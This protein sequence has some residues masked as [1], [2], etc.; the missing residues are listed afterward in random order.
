MS[1]ITLI[2]SLKGNNG[3]I[4]SVSWSLSGDFLI[5]IGT[6]SSLIIWGP[7][8][9]F[10]NRKFYTKKFSE[11]IYFKSWDK[12]HQLKFNKNLRTFRCLNKKINSN[13]F[14]ISDFLGQTYLWEIIFLKSSNICLVEIKH[15]LK[16]HLSE[17]K[18]CGF[19]PIENLIATC[20]RD[21]SIWI[22]KNSFK[23]KIDCEFIF[24]ENKSDIKCI[25]WNPYG[26]ELVASTYE[27]DIILILFGKNKTILRI[28]FSNS[29]SWNF[30]FDGMGKELIIGDGIGEL[31]WVNLNL[32]SF[33]NFFKRKK[34]KEKMWQELLLLFFFN[35][36]SLLSLSNSNKNGLC[37]LGNSNGLINM[38][39]IQKIIKQSEFSKYGFFLTQGSFFLKNF[40][41]ISNLHFG[42]I[43][44][45]VW[46]PIFENVLVSCG[47]DSHINIWRI[48]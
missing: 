46:H 21:K 31:I 35:N 37:L 30:T 8:G 34:K 14:S 45:I 47:D 36:E 9:N 6:N 2:N 3:I 26:T 40:L 4:W 22:W 39:K 29:V 12:L 16:G 20:G 38:I 42:K 41:F 17:I 32:L 1:I 48:N 10:F 19:S 43:N 28:K 27:G 11:I 24:K 5:S 18:S 33:S 13:Y 7:C 44:S 25:K 15:I 23:K